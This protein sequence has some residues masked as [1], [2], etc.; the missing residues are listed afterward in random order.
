MTSVKQR[1]VPC[2]AKFARKVNNGFAIPVSNFANVQAYIKTPEYCTSNCANQH[3]H[4]TPKQVLEMRREWSKG[5]TSV[6]D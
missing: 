6:I 2:L 3:V 4:G 1:E 5:C